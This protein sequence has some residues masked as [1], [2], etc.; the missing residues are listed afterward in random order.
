MN[1]MTACPRYDKCSAPICPLDPDWRLRTHLPEDRVCRWLTELAKPGGET[2]LRE[3]LARTMV[4]QIVQ[5]APLIRNLAPANVKRAIDRASK[6]GSTLE[7]HR[8]LARNL[9]HGDKSPHSGEK[10]LD[11]A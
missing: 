1:P 11:A 7:H 9:R 10:S 4:D 3:R 5:I 8:K 2:R 6:T